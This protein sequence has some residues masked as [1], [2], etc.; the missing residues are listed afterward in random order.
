MNKNELIKEIYNLSISIWYKVY[1]NSARGHPGI[2]GPSAVDEEW[3][4]ELGTL[5]GIKSA[6]NEIINKIK[7]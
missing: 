5:I 3:N 4:E 2:S 6:L 1:S 7:E